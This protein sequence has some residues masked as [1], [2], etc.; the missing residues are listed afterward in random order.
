[1]TSTFFHG[2]LR[3]FPKTFMISYGSS[4]DVSND[5]LFRQ[6]DK[7]FHQSQDVATHSTII[8]QINSS[9]FWPIKGGICHAFRHLGVQIKIMLLLSFFVF[10]NV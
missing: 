5:V 10:C 4:S 8:H 7:D 2:K 6:E 9:K 1:M 3:E